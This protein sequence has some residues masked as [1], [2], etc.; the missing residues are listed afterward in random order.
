[1]VEDCG[2][3]LGQAADT[4]AGDT[5][6]Q[7]YSRL[8]L[9]PLPN[10]VTRRSDATRDD[11]CSAVIDCDRAVEIPARKRLHGS[12]NAAT[13]EHAVRDVQCMR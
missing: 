2:T 7:A 4:P 1:M 9:K 5:I 8:V 12:R 11:G 3:V 13:N 6:E 10:T